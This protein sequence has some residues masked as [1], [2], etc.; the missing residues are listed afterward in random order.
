MPHAE[1]FVALL[2][3]VVLA[4]LAARRLE[5]IPDAVALV[6]AGLVAGLLPFAPAVRI[7]PAVIFIVFLPPILYPSAFAFA[8][9]DVRGSLRPIGFLAIGLVLATI[10]AIAAAMHLVGGIPW[11]SAAVLGAVMAP[12][13]PIS[14]T[15]VIRS[16]GAPARIAT[17]LEGESL[18]NDG[19]ALTALKIAV[20]AVGGS[21]S[22]ATALGQFVLVALGGAAIG[23][24]LGWLA[25]QL[26]RRLDDLELETAI[27]VLLAYGA[28]ILADRLGV[29]GVL[30]VVLAGY[31]TG[32]SDN[33]ATPGTRLGGEWFW[34]VT[35][36]LA[37]SILFLLVGIAFSRILSGHPGP[38]GWR[39][40]GLSALLVGAAVAVR[41]AWMFSVPYL[42]GLFEGER[43]SLGAVIGPRERLVL[44]TGGLRGAL[45]MAAALSIPSAVDGTAFPQRSTVVA[46][47][48]V[49][50][51]VL[52]VLP[53]LSL[54]WI[55]GAVGLAG[56]GRGEE[57]ARTA[58]A[59]LAEAALER[60]DELAADGVVDGSTLDRVRERYA[61][62]LARATTASGEAAGEAHAD[63]ATIRRVR[64]EALAAQRSR[65]RELRR[66]GEV[67]GSLLRD[68]ERELDIEELRSG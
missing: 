3:A 66:A 15:A 40:A 35:R 60:T 8:F 21:L 30:A 22:I 48:I 4:A 28:F 64:R 12:T 47:A 41:F 37:E 46:V 17:T 61:L 42:A 18:I 9:E 63:G 25:S 53:A 56:S 38:G 44:S 10:A 68:L 45:S 20:V 36:F 27:A 5:A 32:R 23:A 52:L 54:R 57:R 31:V 13:D 1:T 6:V 19:T 51:V 49:S 67:H 2:I 26:R 50:I 59:A 62:Q 11:S 16:A 29:S 58:R 14:A 7:D 39:V 24:T 43:R 55:L 33:I 34:S 65:L